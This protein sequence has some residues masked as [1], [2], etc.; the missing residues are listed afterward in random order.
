MVM[1]MFHTVL[2]R[3]IISNC[4]F[5]PCWKLNLRVCRWQGLSPKELKS[6][7]EMNSSGG[8]KKKKKKAKHEVKYHCFL[9]WILI[10][11]LFKWISSIFFT[12]WRYA[13]AVY[14]VVLCPTSV[15]LSVTRRY[16]TKTAKP[17]IMRTTPYNAQCSSFPVPNIL[18][19]FQW[20]HPKRG[21]QIE[22]G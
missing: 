22:V 20:G 10:A 19:K 14:A 4:C 17:K 8:S 11:S 3:I 13:S 21:R 15:H 9:E 6:Y 18:A 16:C 5:L 2:I 1:V 12:A 7:E